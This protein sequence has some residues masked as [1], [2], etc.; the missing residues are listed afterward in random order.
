MTPPPNEVSGGFED[1][2]VERAVHSLNFPKASCRHCQCT[3]TVGQAGQTIWSPAQGRCFPCKEKGR[4]L[5]PVK[6]KFGVKQ[7]PFN[8]ERMGKPG[9]A[10]P[11]TKGH[12]HLPESTLNKEEREGRR[13]QTG[14][15]ERRDQW[16]LSQM[17]EAE[18]VIW[19]LDSCR[20]CP[21]P[22]DCPSGDTERRRL[23]EEEI[24]EPRGDGW[25][26]FL[27]SEASWATYW[28]VWRRSLGAGAKVLD[29]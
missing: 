4:T 12:R 11:S 14:W 18:F 5:L 26:I 10:E 2:E 25:V 20:Q 15:G 9:S 8:A 27:N 24:E 21:G 23:G 13:W 16:P 29:T 3:C 1:S 28:K 17:Q 7:T 6:Q 22:G 19:R